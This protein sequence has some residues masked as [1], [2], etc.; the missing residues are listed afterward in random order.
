MPPE[1]VRGPAHRIDL[2]AAHAVD[3]GGLLGGEV[4]VPPELLE[5]AHVEF[6]VPVGDL[7]TGRIGSIGSRV[8]PVRSRPKRARNVPPPSLMC[9]FV[10]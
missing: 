6:R 5:D 9:R 1:Q 4:L 7:R 8:S 2:V 3:D 10:L